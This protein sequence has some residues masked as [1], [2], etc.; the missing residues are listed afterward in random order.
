M[1][2]CAVTQSGWRI[3]SSLFGSFPS[4]H[5][6]TPFLLPGYRKQNN[7]TQP[8]LFFFF[9]HRSQCSVQITVAPSA[10]NEYAFMVQ[11]PPESFSCRC[12]KVILKQWE[13]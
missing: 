10:L 2:M 1:S 3:S 9:Q 12:K 13:K 7:K 6:L 8:P 4:M 11:Q 5:L